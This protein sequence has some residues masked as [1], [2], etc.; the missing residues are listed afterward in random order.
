VPEPL[1]TVEDLS[2]GERVRLSP[3]SS[4]LPSRFRGCVDDP[5]LPYEVELTISFGGDR[6]VC[7]QFACHQRKGGAPITSAGMTQIRVADLVYRAAR[8][9]LREQSTWSSPGRRGLLV[10]HDFEP[11][12]PPPGR[13][14]PTI[15]H[16]RASG[17]IYTLAYACG[18]SPRKEVMEAL[19]LPRTTANRWIRL[20][21]EQG[22]LPSRGDDQEGE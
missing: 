12:A 16:L 17:Q 1:I 21:R 11:P 8:E 3:Y 20:A 19:G 5:N 10:L 7:E 9:A 13:S 18:G 4:S 22:Q 6:V 15:D 14:G 2:D